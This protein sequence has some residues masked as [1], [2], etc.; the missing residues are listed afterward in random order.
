MYFSATA[1][2][3]GSGVLGAVGVVTLTKVKHRREL[4]FASLPVLFAVHHFPSICK[5]VITGA[6]RVCQKIEPG[7]ALLTSGI[8]FRQRHFSCRLRSMARN[9][10]GPP[11]VAAP[12]LRR[13]SSRIIVTFSALNTKFK[14]TGP[15]AAVLDWK[16][17]LHLS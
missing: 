14:S 2:F 8:P 4:L 9:R 6:I 15:R 16:N 17:E 10:P 5:E 13:R 1:N 11:V 3:V 12:H 7:R